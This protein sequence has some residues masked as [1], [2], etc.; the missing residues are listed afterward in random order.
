MEPAMLSSSDH[1]LLPRPFYQAMIQHARTEL[2]N[3]CCGLLAGVRDG[4]V[5]RV[6]ALHPLVNESASPVE[7]LSA[8]GSLIKAYKEMRQ[9]GHDVVAIYHSHPTSEPVPSKK[10]LER[11][12]HGDGVVHFIIGLQGAEPIVCGWWLTEATF[13]GAAWEI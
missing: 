13:A 4:A 9:R 11:N 8:S 7:Y 5:L 12:F 10:D 6:E 2:P 3:E 1:L